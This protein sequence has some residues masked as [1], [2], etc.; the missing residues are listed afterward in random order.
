MRKKSQGGNPV[1][2]KKRESH[3]SKNK[4]IN[5]SLSWDKEKGKKVTDFGATWGKLAKEDANATALITG[6]GLVVV[7]IDTKDLSKID[8][9][10][11]SMLPPDPT[12]STARG[13]HYYF[14]YDSDVEYLTTTARVDHVDIRSEGGLIFDSYTGDSKNISYEKVGEIYELTPELAE[15]LTVKKE[16]TKSTH[17]GKGMKK[18]EVKQMLSY[19]NVHDYS[20]RDSWMKILA[21]IFDG[22]GS[23][24]EKIARKWSQCDS[25]QYDDGSF[26]SIWLQLEC[27]QYGSSISVGTLM[28]EATQ[29]GYERPSGFIVKEGVSVAVPAYVPPVKI[30]DKKPDQFDINLLPKDVQEF[31]SQGAD[32]L[33]NSPSSM[34]GVGVMVMLGNAI[35]RRVGVRV[36]QNDTWTEHPNFWGALI[37]PPSF[38]KSPIIK[39]VS[40]PIK[41]AEGRAHDRHKEKKD[42]YTQEMAIYRLNKNMYDK[43]FKEGETKALPPEQPKEPARE[44][45]MVSDA[46]IEAVGQIMVDNPNGIL[47]LM[48]ELSG[49]FARLTSAS[50]EADRAF[51]LEAYT[52]QTNHPIDRIGRGSFIIPHMIAG[53]FGSIQPDVIQKVV[54]DTKK[55]ATGG[56]GLLQ[57]FQL[58]VVETQSSYEFKDTGIESKYRESYFKLFDKVLKRSPKTHGARVDNFNPFESDIKEENK[59]YYYKFTKEATKV[60]EEW[61]KDNHRNITKTEKH[62]PALSAHFGK[63]SGT[64]AK[65]ALVLFYCDRITGET[66]ENTID[67]K[68]ARKAIEWLKFLESHARL[69]YDIGDIEEKEEQTLKN[70]IIKKA[71]EVELPIHLGTLGGYVRGANKKICKKALK[72]VAEIRGSKIIRLL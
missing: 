23:K 62:N 48:D 16:H 18:K 31:V 15:W 17:T 55:G 46:T 36:K 47:L 13:F 63:Y 28:H 66:K 72:G 64:F 70:K 68:Y 24:G 3:Y 11:V 1:N 4:Q 42:K 52:H 56:D 35:G 65:L 39:T 44:R 14:T 10:L 37:A 22:L 29:N 41:L 7:D 20:D 58:A 51:W 38:K 53:I 33:D 19:L 50:R 60:F 25:E 27:G 26:D 67:V 9:E 2:T 30:D 5:V 57:R 32:A 21:S 69:I 40:A 6:D 61:S 49:F 8:K 71:R 34:F 43:D 45:H 59:T 12:I 54:Y